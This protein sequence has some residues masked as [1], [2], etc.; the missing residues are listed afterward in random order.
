M[1]KT[2]LKRENVRDILHEKIAKNFLPAK[3]SVVDELPINKNGK[4]D[5]IKANLLMDE[6]HD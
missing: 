1:S 6:N 2:K 4:F 5:V 3:I